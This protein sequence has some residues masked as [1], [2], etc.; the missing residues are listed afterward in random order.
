MARTLAGLAVLVAVVA[1]VGSEPFLRALSSVDPGLVFVALVLSAVATVAAA[2][3]WSTIAGRLGVALGVREAVAWYYRSQFLNTVVPGGVVGDVE[4]AV[5]QGRDAGNLPQAA[6]AVVIE[7]TVGQLVQVAI[8]VL[9]LVYLG[10]EFQGVLLPVLGIGLVLLVLAV[11][12]TAASSARARRAMRRELGELAAGIG[13]PVVLLRVVIASVVVVGCHVATLGVA[14]A[15]VGASVPPLRLAALALVVLVSGSIPLNVGG[16]GPREGV[17]GWA[18]A[19]A[20]LGA[21]TGV[22]ASALFGVLTMISVAPGL[23]VAVGSTV[24]R[25]RTHSATP[26]AVLTVAH[27]GVGS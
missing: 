18:F 14:V 27:R 16:W 7:R 23:V 8:A 1:G 19:V 11:L 4:R 15:A 5:T 12:G 3:R 2:W 22:A 21:S 26:P 10:S 25:A 20:G 24:R 6:R 17:A 9:V 13:S